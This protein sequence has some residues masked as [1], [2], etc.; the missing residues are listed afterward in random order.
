MLCSA[1]EPPPCVGGPGACRALGGI[2]SL[3]TNKSVAEVPL[4]CLV[5]E[6]L[7]FLGSFRA[8]A[9][10]MKLGYQVIPGDPGLSKNN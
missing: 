2:T 3:W 7:R 4:H 9:C 8:L 6:G 1:K 5:R 10:T